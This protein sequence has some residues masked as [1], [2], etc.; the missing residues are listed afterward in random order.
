V[1]KEG[2]G[3]A[4]QDIKYVLASIALR[5][6]NIG[7]EQLKAGWITSLVVVLVIV[8]LLITRKWYLARYKPAVEIDA[9]R[10]LLDNAALPAIAVQDLKEVL[11]SRLEHMSST[12]T[13]ASAVTPMAQDARLKRLDEL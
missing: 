6:A 7:T 12:S 2:A 11:T 8:G 1:G 10:S 5:S 9:L 4:K 3:V 13:I